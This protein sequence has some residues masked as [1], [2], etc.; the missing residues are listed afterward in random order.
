MMPPP[1]KF[2]Y[3]APAEAQQILEVLIKRGI[4]KVVGASPTVTGDFAMLKSVGIMIN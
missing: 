3:V 2:I 4:V 1:A